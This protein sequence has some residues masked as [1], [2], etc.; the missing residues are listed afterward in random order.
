M[1]DFKDELYW[2]A[3][4]IMTDE[5]HKSQISKY[6]TTIPEVMSL[7][8]ENKIIYMKSEELEAQKFKKR[9]VKDEL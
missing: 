1:T 7:E 8:F 9:K 2:F 4:L 5:S 3:N 6:L